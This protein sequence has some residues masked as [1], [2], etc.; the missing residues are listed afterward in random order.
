MCMS[1]VLCRSVVAKYILNELK[2]PALSRGSPEPGTLEL[3]LTYSSCHDLPHHLEAEDE[4]YDR[5]VRV[6]SAS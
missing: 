3:G 4:I 6:S 2:V 5:G 1:Q